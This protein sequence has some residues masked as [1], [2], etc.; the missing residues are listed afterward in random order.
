[1]IVTEVYRHTLRALLE[2]KRYII[3]KGGSR[4]SKTFSELQVFKTIADHS[5]KQEINTIV[6]HS[7]P[8]LKGG[9]IRDF[10]NILISEG[11]QPDL[12]RIKNPYEYR[13][14]SQV[15]EF[16]SFDKI[17]KALGGARDRLFINEANKMPF[18]ICHHLMQRTTGSVFIDYN[19]SHK[20][21]VDE[22][23]YI[24]NPESAVIHSTF[25]DN[26][27]NLSIGQIQDFE[28]ARERAMIEEAND[29]KGYWYNWW[30]VYGL[31]LDGIVEG[32]IFHNWKKGEFD[33]T[34]PYAF[35][36]D[37][38]SKDPDALIKCAIDRGRKLIYLKEEIYKNGQ[39]TFDLINEIKK[40]NVGNKLIIAD[41]S[42]KRT[43]Q[44]LEGKGLNIRAV[45]SKAILPGIKL[46]QDYE[47]IIEPNSIN[48]IR[49]LTNYVWTDRRGEIPVDFD[50]HAIDAARYIITTMI[51]PMPRAKTKLIRHGNI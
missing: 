42:A 32:A 25:M 9:A 21:W 50:N 28:A 27:Q 2:N 31:G 26:I 24:N 20:F 30:R 51:N 13:I 41:S 39:G 15:F 10:D 1:M 40:C 29:N 47:M 19:P 3:N 49:E 14:G 43:I 38:G 8:H 23:G 11:I 5:K 36:L 22:N 16:I 45:G 4:S 33:N 18:A 48:L 17:G 7:L 35:G 6:S 46:M 44:D 12:V 34:L 37:F